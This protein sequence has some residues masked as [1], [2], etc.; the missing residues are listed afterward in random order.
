MAPS[1][2]TKV[3]PPSPSSLPGLAAVAPGGTSAIEVISHGHFDR[4]G[5]YKPP[6]DPRQF[7]ML[8][9]GNGGMTPGLIDAAQVLA[10]QGALVATIDTG[11][12]IEGFKK[13]KASCFFP[14]GDLENLSHYI[15]AYYKLG[16]YLVPILVGYSSGATIV[17]AMISRAA[18]DIFTGAVLVDASR[19]RRSPSRCASRT[20]GA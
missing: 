2:P 15:Q 7:V 10:G 13:D 20:R 6:H 12:L 1:G 17:H 19:S 18:P 11:R 8:L 9:S 5:I 4:V 3:P 16:A 14:D